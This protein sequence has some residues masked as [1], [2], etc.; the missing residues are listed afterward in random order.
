MTAREFFTFSTWQQGASATIG[1]LR[2]AFDDPRAG[3]KMSMTRICAI[4][5]ML[6]ALYTARAFV[7]FVFQYH[8]SVGM[9]GVIAGAVTTLLTAGVGAMLLHKRGDGGSEPD[10]DAPST[11]TSA[12]V[13]NINAPAGNP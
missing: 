4:L 1:Y 13:V 7:A 10:D 5:S 3:G 12:P 11:V 6:A 9:A 8:E 2:S